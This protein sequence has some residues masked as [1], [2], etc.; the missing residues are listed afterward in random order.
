MSAVIESYIRFRVLVTRFPYDRE[1]VMKQF[2]QWYEQ[3]LIHI[4]SA[5]EDGTTLLM[6]AAMYDAY[7]LFDYL[8]RIGA[9][10][11]TCLP[12]G[13]N[14]LYFVLHHPCYPGRQSEDRLKMLDQLDRA[15]LRFNDQP[16]AWQEA[17]RHACPATLKQCIRMWSGDLSLEVCKE[18]LKKV[19]PRESTQLTQTIISETLCPF[20]QSFIRFIG[21]YV[22]S[23]VFLWTDREFASTVVQQ[24]IHHNENWR[25]HRVEM[26]RV[27]WRL[28]SGVPRVIIL[29]MLMGPIPKV[30]R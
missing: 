14:V 22:P 6:E 9:N 25:E 18:A 27:L 13:E 15:G 4:D 11:H 28:P 12:A 17:L 8:L 16:R 24:L 10:P 19:M 7:D 21:E 23:H 1:N 5:D 3:G 2:R 30:L 26:D 29:D 20:D